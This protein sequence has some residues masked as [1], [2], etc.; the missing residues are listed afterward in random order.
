[1]S[2]Y[3]VVMKNC[4]LSSGITKIYGK[5][6]DNF[7]VLSTLGAHLLKEKKLN[8]W[9]WFK[10]LL[11]PYKGITIKNLLIKSN[12]WVLISFFIIKIINLYSDSSI[13]C[14][15]LCPYSLGM[16]MH[17]LL[18]NYPLKLYLNCSNHWIS[19]I[20]LLSAYKKWSSSAQIMW[21]MTTLN[22]V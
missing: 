6:R 12:N 2:F 16:S 21:W 20:W 14:L 13:N 17:C 8:C 9:I 19:L 22:K 3:Q 4:R 7:K 15:S 18:I 5:K 10:T 11:S 1:M